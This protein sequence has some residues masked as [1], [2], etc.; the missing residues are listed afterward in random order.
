M[1]IELLGMAMA[2]LVFGCIAMPVAFWRKLRSSFSFFSIILFGS[3]LAAHA[4]EVPTTPANSWTGS[5][6]VTGTV[7]SGTTG[8]TGTYSKTTPSGLTVSGT[9][10]G[11]FTA[12]AS[13]G[14]SGAYFLSPGGTNTTWLNSTASGTPGPFT[15]NPTLPATMNGLAFLTKTQPCV[16]SGAA[17]T[18]CTGLGTYRFTMTDPIGGAVPVVNPRM[19]ITRIG[20]TVGAMELGTGLQ[21]NAGAS[22]PGISFSSIAG[23]ASATFTI[24]ATEVFGNPNAP[25][26]TLNVNCGVSATTTAGCGSVQVNGNLSILQLNLKA[27]RTTAGPNSWAGGGDAYAVGWSFDEDFGG[28]PTTYEGGVTAAAHL[29]TD[30]RLGSG[31]TAENT[32]THNGNSTGTGLLTASPLAAAAGAAP[33]DTQDALTSMPVLNTSQIGSIYSVTPTISGAS[34]SGDL[35][36]W[37]DFDRSGTF[38]AAEGVCA[39]FTAGAT[40]VPLIF[41]VPTATTAGSTYARFRVT[42]DTNIG[43]ANFNGLYSSG[44]VED[45]QLQIMPA[46][47]VVKAV[48]PLPD[49]G[50]FNL[51]VNGTTF[52]SAIGNT[53]T[54]NFRTVY[55]NGT[56]DVTVA[57]NVA[58]A[59]ITGVILSEAAAGATVLANYATTVACVNGAGTAV[60]PGGTATAPTVTIPQSLTGASANGRAQTIT[61]TLTN[62]RRPS[63]TLT[64]ALGSNRAADTDQFVVAI[65]TG[66]SS[67]PVVNVTTNSTTSGAG[68]TVT[69][70]TTGTFTAT[71][72]TPYTLTEAASGTTNFAQYTSAIT[73]T[74]SA[75]LQTGLPS[76]AAYTVAS[77]LTIT[78]VAGATISC[79]LTNT[80]NNPTLTLAKS[81]VNTGGGTAAATAWTLSASGPTNI[82]GVTAAP[83]V[84]ATAV[85][86][87][88][89]TLSE[90]GGP[91]DLNGGAADYTASTYSCVVNG[92]AAV[93]G[94]SITLNLGDTT[95]CTITNTFVADPNLTIDKRLLTGTTLPLQANQVITYEF[96]VTNTGNVPVTDLNIEETAF[97]G[98]GTIGAFTPP[99]GTVDLAPGASTIV[100]ATYTVSQADVD[101]LQ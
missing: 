55:H 35:C 4:F 42:Y 24:S 23:A 69:G 86:A 43:T 9:A 62:T 98:T 36:G 44:E 76:G 58:N 93:S 56:P 29:V 68:S 90:S 25:G 94:N 32:A 74:D 22:S 64:K 95:V 67:G 92:A 26:T 70:G 53:G 31:V 75:G 81:V 40:S 91:A 17:A 87:G 15:S 61:C 96:E 21:I 48:T 77:G 7:F 65:R 3:T 59:A 89:Y 2:A 12:G 34:R 49:T 97:T 82:S 1:A 99:N 84:T 100:T 5:G 47:R 30:L 37:I 85:S 63:I 57:T 6:I 101:L 19:H 10:N 72:G 38:S 28:A 46:V 45:Y 8:E 83:T 41:T 20:G 60:T 18:V 79:T 33:G 50:T 71:A 66:G 16:T 27:Y 52:A 14:T 78:P 80:A 73:C 13:S 39:A 51:L 54:T 11:Q 88:A